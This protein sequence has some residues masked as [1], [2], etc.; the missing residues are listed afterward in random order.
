MISL[1]DLGLDP[2]RTDDLD[3]ACSNDAGTSEPGADT[4]RSDVPRSGGLVPGS[5]LAKTVL[6]LWSGSPIVVLKSPPG[7]GKTTLV[8]GICELLSRR[9][10]WSIVVATPT[11]RAAA[12]LAERIA[13]ELGCP[14][15]GAS[16]VV[17]N[18]V[19]G[20]EPTERVRTK[21]YGAKKAVVV[22]TLASCERSAP[23]C[24]L[25]VVDEA[26]QA[27][28]ATVADAA[29]SADQLLLVG[30]PGQIGPVVT[31]N[32][33]AWAGL[34]HAPHR[35]A[36][37]VFALDPEAVVLNLDSSYRLGPDT[38]EVIRPLYDFVFESQRGVRSV[39][40]PS[41]RPL[42]EVAAVQVPPAPSVTDLGHQLV[43]ADLIESY[44]GAELAVCTPDGRTA[45]ERL[46]ADDLC[47][48]T[49]HNVQCDAIAAILDAR[50][51]GKV[52]CGTA[53]RLQGGQ[54]HV[55]IAVDPLMGHSKAGSH[56]LS[57]GRLCVMAS[58]HMTH[59]VWV[60]DGQHRTIL[61]ALADEG[62]QQ[63]SVGAQVRDGVLAIAGRPITGGAH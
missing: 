54:W 10:E 60:H 30:D 3:P 23:T 31:A 51:L 12:D 21:R 25:F 2:H 33:A 5:V 52:T 9:T 49:S 46:T 22:R 55:V 13:E 29:A 62:D 63:A 15:P 27:T 7:A 53:D 43:V 11:R 19:N 56:Q 48:V 4:T 57:P 59:L 14:D 45:N 42:A 28:Y 6:H 32:T 1:G 50:G 8:A 18:S 61:S 39:V 16:A 17:I 47:V 24:D 34:P 20:A 38:V 44:V 40:D 35:R 36:P 37:E 41:G 26:Y 58:R